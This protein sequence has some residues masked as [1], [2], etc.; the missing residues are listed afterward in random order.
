M[1]LA[2]VKI[3]EISEMKTQKVWLVIE[4]SR[5]L[6]R[7]L[8]EEVLKSGDRLVATARNIAEVEPL[9]AQFGEAVRLV[10]VDVRK[11]HQVEAAVRATTR[12]FGKLDVLVNNAGHG[13]GDEIKVMTEEVFREHVDMNFWGMIHT[14]R[15]ALPVLR[16]QGFG[17]ILQITSVN[18]R[19]GTPDLSGYYAAK[20]AIERISEAVASDVALSGITVCVVETDSVRADWI[21]APL[22]SVEKV[23]SYGRS[24]RIFRSLMKTVYRISGEPVKAAREILE[25]TEGHIPAPGC[26][27]VKRDGDIES[28]TSVLGRV[29]EAKETGSLEFS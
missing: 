10:T 28:A 5:G 15:S 8:A 23:E 22:S 11:S 24:A 27:I 26:Q 14:M 2:N 9:V 7:A 29:V 4:T 19:P 3:G 20:S 21:G 16:A 18:G 25:L 13:V 1:Q 6:G 17:H 12:I